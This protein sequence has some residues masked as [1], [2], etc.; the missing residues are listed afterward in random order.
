M[1]RCPMNREHTRTDGQ[2]KQ[3]E[4]LRKNQKGMLQIKNTVRETNASDG[5][6]RIVN[7]QA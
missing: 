7:G 1:L 3:R 2:C 6:I 5:L 4:I